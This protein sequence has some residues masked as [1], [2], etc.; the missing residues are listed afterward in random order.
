MK[1]EPTLSKVWQVIV[2]W[3]HVTQTCTWI[4]PIG[5]TVVEARKQIEEF[6]PRHKILSVQVM[7]DTK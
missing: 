1:V 4:V 3:N 7:E 2:E 6:Y 5:I